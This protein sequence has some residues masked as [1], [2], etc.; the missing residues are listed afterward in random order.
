MTTVHDL[1]LAVQQLP[2]ADLAAFRRWFFQSDEAV[3]D[4][5][6]QADAATGKLDDLATQALTDYAS[7]KAKEL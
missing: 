4:V 2:A 7:G 1:E 5:Q 3:W 6:M